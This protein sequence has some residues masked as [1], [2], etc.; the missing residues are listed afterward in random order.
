MKLP[1]VKEFDAEDAVLVPGCGRRPLWADR[2]FSTDGLRTG[3]IQSGRIGQ[4]QTRGHLLLQGELGLWQ[5]RTAGE[6][7]VDFKL[8]HAE[9]PLQPAGNGIGEPLAQ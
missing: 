6:R 5:V 9:N 3:I 8:G 4:G 1:L 7:G 2:E